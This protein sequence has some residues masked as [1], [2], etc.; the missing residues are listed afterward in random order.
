[1][2]LNV[3]AVS[4][5]SLIV[6]IIFVEILRKK[7]TF[8]DFLSW[9][10]VIF[11][12]VYPLPAFL[13]EADFDHQ[14]IVLM[15]DTQTSYTTEIRTTI[16]I[17]LGYF[18]VVLGFYNNSAKRFGKFFII[19]KNKN[20]KLILYSICLLSF[21]FLSIHLYSS[22]YGGIL[23]AISQTNLIRAGAA[24][25][26]TEGTLLFFK[27][28][29]FTSFF[30]SY[31]LASIVFIGKMKQNRIAILVIFILSVVISFVAV[32]LS[33]G[34]ITLINYCLGFYL[35]SIICN[36]KINL[37]III[38]GLLCIF[39]IIMYGKAFFF[40]L[41]AIPNGFEN[42]MDTFVKTLDNESEKTTKG[43]HLYTFIINFVFPVHSLDAS[44]KESYNP[45]FFVDLFYA[46]LSII[47]SRILNAIAGIELPL[48]I[49]D[50][51]S[52]YVL[53]ITPKPTTIPP[54]LLAYGIY[55]MSWP[56]LIIVSLVYGWIGRFL[57]S[58]LIE[59][60]QD[61]YW[62]PFIYV[63]TLQVWADF[64]PTGDLRLYLVNYFWFLLS[65][66]ILLVFIGKIYFRKPTAS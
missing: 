4:Y 3:V 40:S 2:E 13:L 50:L 11:C 12:L 7:E 44:F 58:I 48:S 32:L 45:T 18:C 16:A 60:I 26:E 34:R 29:I 42:V 24:S 21:A 6:F 65:M 63:L 28:F 46:F 25:T 33:S 27:Q 30:S 52:V 57:Q 15:Y 20:W 14:S 53:K 61:I 64:T 37:K 51:N 39:L 35:V 36:G 54:G 8:V 41:T 56:G 31:L 1:M 19:Q 5:L 47:P 55:S 22:E 49:A 66:T 10:N 62:I 9:F 17:F 43:N 59:Y 23:L 38:P